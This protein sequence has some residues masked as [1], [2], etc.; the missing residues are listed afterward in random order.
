MKI[1]NAE[2]EKSVRETLQ[3]CYAYIPRLLYRQEY[4]IQKLNLIFKTTHYRS[5]KIDL[6]SFFQILY[7]LEYE[8]C[9][10]EIRYEHTP[11]ANI[12]LSLKM[13]E[14]NLKKKYSGIMLL[15]ELNR[16]ESLHQR[17]GEAIKKIQLLLKQVERSLWFSLKKEHIDRNKLAYHI[18]KSFDNSERQLYFLDWLSNHFIKSRYYDAMCEVLH[19]IKS[20]SDSTDTEDTEPM[21]P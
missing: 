4:I 14:K 10:L 9:Q 11:Q 15:R 1:I 19:T 8:M 16:S 17:R 21:T 7:L 6:V 18:F 3:A 12:Q 13:A 20:Q 2:L 5:G